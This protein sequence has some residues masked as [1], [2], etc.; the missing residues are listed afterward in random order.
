MTVVLPRAGFRLPEFSIGTLCVAVGFAVLAIPTM[1]SLADQTWSKE[2]G[3]YGPIVLVTGL[4]LLWRQAPELRR[5]GEPG[6]FWVTSAILATAIVFYVF[7]KAF[8]F[9]TLESTGVYGV[10]VAILQTRVGSKILLKHWFPLLYLAF[11]I[12]VPSS[13][14]ADLTS[15][16]KQLVSLAATDWLHVFGVPVARQGVT[17]FVGQYQLLVEDACS[18]MNSI[19]GLIAV[20]LLYIYLTRGTSWLYAI[21]LVMFVVPIAIVANIFRIMVLILLTYYFGNDVAQGYLHFAAGMLL[22]TTALL[23]VFSLDRLIAY[24]QSRLGHAA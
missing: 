1:V 21:I 5:D 14:L 19:V 4:W 8:D 13:F 9:I 17:I 3:A 2:F 22:F 6:S 20:S 12:P 11:V 18:G 16:L 10:G 7:G 24:G 23:F 15:P